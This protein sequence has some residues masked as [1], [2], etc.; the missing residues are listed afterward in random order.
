MKVVSIGLLLTLLALTTELH[1]QSP[2]EVLSVRFDESGQKEVQLKKNLLWTFTDDVVEAP[3]MT[4]P[5][6][7]AY[8]GLLSVGEK[9]YLSMDINIASPKAGQIYGDLT[10]GKPIKLSFIDE[11]VI[12]LDLLRSEPPRLEKDGLSTT[13]S[14]LALLDKKDVKAI[15]KCEWDT[16]GLV[17]SGG[18]EEYEIYHVDALK[19]QYQCLKKHIK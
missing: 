10:V 18:Y 17:W 11:Q 6:I 3:Q 12:Y 7:M 16:I 15:R 5:F 8:G 9:M 14:I 1:A 19:E 13:Y 2:C 4:R